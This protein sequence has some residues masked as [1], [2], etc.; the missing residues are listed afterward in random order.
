MDEKNEDGR[1]TWQRDR[2]NIRLDCIKRV[3]TG[4]PS[5]FNV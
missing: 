2:Q 1:L 4:S 3:K 5:V